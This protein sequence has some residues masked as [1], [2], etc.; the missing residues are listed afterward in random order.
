MTGDTLGGCEV[1][2]GMQDLTCA[3]PDTQK[4]NTSCVRP[5]RRETIFR[6]PHRDSMWCGDWWRHFPRQKRH[7]TAEWRGSKSWLEVKEMQCQFHQW[8]WMART[9]V[10][11]PAETEA[12]KWVSVRWSTQHGRGN[13]LRQL[14]TSA[15]CGGWTDVGAWR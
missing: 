7:L 13:V 1:W 10:E 4:L 12:I 2:C 3:E 9:W 6:T 8:T 14:S 5:R 15:L 11:G